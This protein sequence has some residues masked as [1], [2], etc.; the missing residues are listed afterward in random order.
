MEGDITEL[1]YAETHRYRP[2]ALVSPEFTQVDSEHPEADR[3]ADGLLITPEQPPA[4]FLA[5]EVRVDSAGA[6]VALAGI[7]S[8]DGDH[9]LAAYDV[10]RQRLTIE[11]RT[12]GRTRV[13]A[14]RRTTLA[15]PFGLAF[16]LCENQITALV[17]QGDGWQPVVTTR[18]NVAAFIDFRRTDVLSRFAY[19]YGTRPADAPVAG[20]TRSPTSVRRIL[21]HLKPSRGPNSQAGSGRLDDPATSET[22]GSTGALA[23]PK[24]TSVRA[25][26]F[27][28]TGVR[29]PHV[30]QFPDGTPYIR[31]SKLY[32]TM[33]CAGLGFFQQAHWGVFTLDLDELT[34]LEQV[35]QLFFSRD[36][37]VLGDHAGQIVIDGDRCIVAVSSWGDFAIGSIHVRH[38]VAGVEVLSGVHVLATEP[39]ALPTRFGAW[40]PALNRINERWYVGFVESPSQDKRFDF[41]PALAVT[42]PGDDYAGPLELVSADDSLHQCEGPILTEVDGH[43]RLA[44]SDSDLREYVLYDLTMHRVGAL[45]APY[46][47]NIPHPQLVTIDGVDG[48]RH[49]MVT[50]DG[51]PYGAAVVGYGGHGDFVIMEALPLSQ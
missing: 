39:F 6:G 1:K 45:D 31:D 5:V 40:D 28:M 2:F 15:P 41:H 29:D 14:V 43:W 8:P 9:A 47:T 27:G 20:P 4:P 44:A 37:L 11:L 22:A 19:A 50:F 46:L 42:A 12:Q 26:L 38:T 16:A 21:S 49:L 35:A 32:L 33:T 48:P 13:V 36:G 18:K 10:A 51:T 7:A 23:Q 25:G 24:V 30:V 34:R 17:D 3:R